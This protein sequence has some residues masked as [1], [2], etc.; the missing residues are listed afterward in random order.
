MSFRRGSWLPAR[1]CPHLNEQ[2]RKGLVRSRVDGPNHVLLGKDSDLGLIVFLSVD[3]G[4]VSQESFRA[5]QQLAGD[6]GRIG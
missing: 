6:L 2:T 5:L 4:S 1:N 3:S